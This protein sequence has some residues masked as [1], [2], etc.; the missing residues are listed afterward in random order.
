VPELYQQLF[1][2]AEGKVTHDEH[3]PKLIE[4]DEPYGDRAELSKRQNAH[5][6]T[7]PALRLSPLTKHAQVEEAIHP[8][9]HAVGDELLPLAVN[10]ENS[11]WFGSAA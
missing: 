7:Q 4:N 11:C 5:R 1:K 6:C 9:P 3:H 2:I 10:Q 8:Y